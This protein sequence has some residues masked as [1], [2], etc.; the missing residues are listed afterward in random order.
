MSCS[1]LADAKEVSQNM[2]RLVVGQHHAFDAK[3]AGKQSRGMLES[4]WEMCERP[5]K[6]VTCCGRQTICVVD[7]GHGQRSEIVSSGA[8]EM[9][10]RDVSWCSLTALAM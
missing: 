4:R 10:T 2:W 3:C 6:G 5:Q 7:G 1:A 9:M 8:C